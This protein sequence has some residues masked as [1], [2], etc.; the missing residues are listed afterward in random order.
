M[1]KRILIIAMMFCLLISVI[2]V[3][4]HAADGGFIQPRWTNTSV[5]TADLTFQGTTG[6]VN[7]WIYGRT[8]VNNI[9]AEIRLYYKNTSGGW[10][11]ITKNWDYSVNQSW[12]SISENF[13]AVAGREYKIEVDATVTM[14]GY[15][16][17]ISK[18]ATAICPR[19]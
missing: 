6:K 3:T 1:K 14:N 17:L 4:T 2:P 18:T 15:S 19:T 16:E 7:V 11:E 12:L 13:T 9:G 10:T 5:F 8:D